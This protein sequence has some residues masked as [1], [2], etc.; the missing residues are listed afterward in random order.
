MSQGEYKGFRYGVRTVL[1]RDCSTLVDF[2]AAQLALEK[3][4]TGLGSLELIEL[5]AVYING[6]RS[7]NCAQALQPGD[8]VRIHTSPRRFHPPHDL[9]H[10]VIAENEDSLLIEKPADLPTEPEIDNLRENLIS[11]LQDLRGQPLFLT[12]RLAAESDGLLLVAKTRTAQTRIMQAF[13]ESR[14]RRRYVVYIESPLSTEKQSKF[15]ILSCTEQRASTSLISEG[16]QTW[17]IV[18]AP[19]QVFYRVEVE[20]TEAR[21]KEL[22][23]FLAAIGSPIIGDRTHGSTHDL[24]DSVNLRPTQA[25]RALSLSVEG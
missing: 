11:F 25:Y 22:R 2:V 9:L 1:C 16:F 12:H 23:E 24:I 10:R 19:L 13:K 20:F 4:P 17:K 6:D 3:E 5:G 18:G 7:L 15:T 14:I 21:P 8:E